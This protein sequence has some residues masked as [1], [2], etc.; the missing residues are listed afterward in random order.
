MGGEVY[1]VDGSPRLSMKS[2]LLSQESG[3]SSCFS[4]L[5]YEIWRKKGENMQNMVLNVSPSSLSSRK[6]VD[7][8]YQKFAMWDPY[9]YFI[10]HVNTVFYTSWSILYVVR[11]NQTLNAT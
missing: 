9:I 7:K 1:V 10:H 3:Y 5:A 2:I 8:I 4:N 6:R 11:E